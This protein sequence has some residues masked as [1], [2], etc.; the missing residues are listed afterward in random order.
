MAGASMTR[1]TPDVAVLLLAGLSHL[2]C[3]ELLEADAGYKISRVHVYPWQREITLRW[4]RDRELCWQLSR[5]GIDE[6]D[7]REGTGTWYNTGRRSRGTE[8]RLR[9]L[10]I[11]REGRDVSEA[12]EIDQDGRDHAR[13]GELLRIPSC[14]IEFYLANRHV[15]KTRYHDEYVQLTSQATPVRAPYLWEMNYVGQYF[16]F[17]LYHHYPCSWTCSATLKRARRAL[18]IVRCASPVWA[19][20]FRR[21]LRGAMI[22]EPGRAVHCIRGEVP[23][24]STTFAGSQVVSTDWSPLGAALRST[25]SIR[26]AMKAG[27]VARRVP[28]PLVLY[29]Q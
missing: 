24:S 25:G 28:T 19:R 11:G 18:R 13:L 22:C 5:F 20:A 29:F 15:A 21:H 10:Y 27:G 3:R 23:R 7:R 1:S 8:G 4:V 6:G 12:R 17:S 9:Y 14:C 26:A 2:Q 16:G